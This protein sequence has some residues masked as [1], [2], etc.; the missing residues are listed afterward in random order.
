M[1]EMHLAFACKDGLPY[2]T[3]KWGKISFH[4]SRGFQEAGTK[5]FR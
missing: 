4:N 5:G 2:T 3:D 1:L